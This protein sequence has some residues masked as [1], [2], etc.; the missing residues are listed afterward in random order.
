MSHLLM[1]LARKEGHSDLQVSQKE[2]VENGM[3]LRVIVSGRAFLHFFIAEKAPSRPT[4]IDYRLLSALLDSG[5][6][7]QCNRSLS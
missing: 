1:D 3:T 6:P 4:H 7:S 2:H 5:L